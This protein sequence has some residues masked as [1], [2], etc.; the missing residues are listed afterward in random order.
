MYFRGAPGLAQAH[1]GF[2]LADAKIAQIV[3]ETR[4]AAKFAR[5]AIAYAH[6]QAG[7]WCL[8]LLYNVEM[9]V[10]GCHFVH[11]GH[12]PVEQGAQ[13]R[14]VRRR[15]VAVMVVD[16]MK[17]LKKKI[18]PKGTGAQEVAELRA[19]M[20]AVRP[21]RDEGLPGGPMEDPAPLREELALLGAEL[22]SP[23]AR[24]AAEVPRLALFDR[25]LLG[26]VEEVEGA[27]RE[28]G[29]D[30]AAPAVAAPSPD[31]SGLSPAA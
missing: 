4:R 28:A 7:R 15:N 18:G 29:V 27:L 14:D 24:L 19:R 6:G 13:C 2:N 25:I 26:R 20:D 17:V 9:R 23:R 8:A 30:D 1:C 21:L 3:A 12:R 10:E 16:L 11:L 5:Q 31:P 22:E